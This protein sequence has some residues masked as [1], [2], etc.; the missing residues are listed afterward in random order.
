MQE[1][2]AQGPTKQR[3]K[4]L[5]PQCAKAKG[6]NLQQAVCKAVLDAFPELSPEDVR[7]T[8]MGCGGED[9][10]LSTLAG[11]L[12][13]FSVECK[14]VENLQLW[15]SM[16]QAEANA[17]SFNNERSHKSV[18][19]SALL[20]FK[21]NHKIMYACVARNVIWNAFCS[22]IG[23]ALSLISPRHYKN[24]VNVWKLIEDAIDAKK[25]KPPSSMDTLVAAA[26]DT[27]TGTMPN[28]KTKR[29][30]KLK[31]MSNTALGKH[32]MHHF[33]CT[34][35][36]DG[37]PIYMI[38][39]FDAFMRLLTASRSSDSHG[40]EE[41]ENEDMTHLPRAMIHPMPVSPQNNISNTTP[42]HH[43]THPE[44]MMYLD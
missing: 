22:P 2:C 13:P 9:V 6:R 19:R 25:P 31:P 29:K 18:P 4:G 43:A 17:N 38:L 30:A 40:E 41:S 5:K 24:K 35:A 11:N 12:W 15:K 33:T 1:S 26:T 37:T 16:E 21:K 20:V 7:S 3:R 44:P 23:D 39:P 32:V 14:N 36:R 27:V 42:L 34:V 10:Q 8:S 28:Y